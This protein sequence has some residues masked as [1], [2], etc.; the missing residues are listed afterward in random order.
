MEAAGDSQPTPLLSQLHDLKST[1]VSS[2]SNA[3]STSATE[4]SGSRTQ[5][6]VVSQ[7]QDVDERGKVS[8]LFYSISHVPAKL[9]A[10]SQNPS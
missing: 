1:S 10:L 8:K 5:L 3:T 9:F 2:S 7:S 6:N 4:Y